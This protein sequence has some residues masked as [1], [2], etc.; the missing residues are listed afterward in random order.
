MTPKQFE[1]RVE[2]VEKL[3]SDLYSSIFPRIF[4]YATDAEMDALLRVRDALS[5]GADISTIP[6]EIR[7]AGER[8]YAGMQK[9]AK[10]S[11]RPRSRKLIPYFP[12]PEEAAGKQEAEQTKGG[13]GGS[14]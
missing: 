13:T 14:E 10:D 4:H 5:G 8:A 7:T 1:K 12:A 9:R 2:K 3:L 11:S 6:V